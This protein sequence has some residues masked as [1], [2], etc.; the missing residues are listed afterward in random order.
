MPEPLADAAIALGGAMLFAGFACAFA[1]FA[2]LVSG[3]RRRV[4]LRAKPS[5]ARQ[6]APPR[7]AALAILLPLLA[8]AVPG[9]LAALFDES[10]VV[11]TAAETGALFGLS[12]AARSEVMLWKRAIAAWG[13]ALGLVTMCASMLFLL[14]HGEATRVAL[15]VCAILGAMGFGAGAAAFRLA[16][17]TRAISRLS[18]SSSRTERVLY[19]L[20]LALIVTLGAGIGLSSASKEFD[21]SALAAGSV[22]A[23]A[24]GVCW[25]GGARHRWRV[26]GIRI[27]A[28]PPDASKRSALARWNTVP[29]AW[30]VAACGPCACEPTNFDDW[31][32]VYPPPPTAAWPPIHHA[33]RDFSRRRR[34]SSR[35]IAADH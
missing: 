34:R 15:Y 5:C 11:V 9:V 10:V 26:S 14:L 29:D 13:C 18:I 16:H 21:V 35:R 23:A 25:M 32:A 22:L 28:A 19:F 30:L 31:I 24:L 27:N 2:A 7:Q 6:V 4:P 3:W 12:L 1:Q 33:S 17:D 8:T 20:A